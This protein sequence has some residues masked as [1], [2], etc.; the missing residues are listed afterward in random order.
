MFSVPWPGKLS[1]GERLAMTH[2]EL[3]PV[4]SGGISQHNDWTG[5]LCGALCTHTGCGHSQKTRE[6]AWPFPAGLS[7]PRA[8]FLQLRPPFWWKQTG[9][10]GVG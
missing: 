8:E 3:T 5:R 1:S 7:H 6:G 2:G 4:C 9:S 10:S